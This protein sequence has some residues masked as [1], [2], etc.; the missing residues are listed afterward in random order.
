MGTLK[1]EYKEEGGLGE[2]TRLALKVLTK[3]M[4]TTQPSADKVELAT[5]VYDSATGA[6]LQRILPDAEVALLLKEL[7]AAGATAGDA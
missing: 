3:A 5:L 1:T 7:A 6:V 4:D 2:A